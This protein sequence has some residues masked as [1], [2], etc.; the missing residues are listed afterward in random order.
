MK[1]KMNQT[2]T[3]GLPYY[4][5]SGTILYNGSTYE[6]VIKG[7]TICGICSNGELL[8]V[9]PEEYILTEE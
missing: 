2:V 4:G 5:K 7:G 6:A 3:P 8:P 9:Q 1:I